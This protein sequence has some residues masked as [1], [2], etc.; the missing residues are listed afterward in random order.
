[1]RLCALTTT[2]WGWI[3]FT[4]RKIRR[5][6][7]SY[8]H[9]SATLTP[10]QI[11]GPIPASQIKIYSPSGGGWLPVVPLDPTITTGL[12]HAQWPTG[13]ET[14]SSTARR[15]L[16][17]S[18]ATEPSAV[19]P[20]FKEVGFSFKANCHSQLDCA[21]LPHECPDE[22]LVDYPVNYLARDF[23]SFRQALI[24]FASDRHPDWQDRLEADVGMMLA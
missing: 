14:E 2:S 12:G 1:M 17:L 18:I 4:S 13:V 7:S 5:R 9:P 3:S 19:D 16:P 6:F 23:W 15:F 24:D 21:A 10:Q 20:Y 8:F 22:E 11:L